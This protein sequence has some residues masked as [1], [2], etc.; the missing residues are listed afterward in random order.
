[1]KLHVSDSSSVHHQEFFTV[2]AGMVSIIQVC[3]QAVSKPVWYTP[4][5]CVQWKTRD[6]GQRNCPKHVVSFQNKIWEISA[7][8]W[9]Y[10]KKGRR[11]SFLKGKV[12]RGVTKTTH[13][14]VVL[15]LQLHGAMPGIPY[16]FVLWQFTLTFSLYIVFPSICT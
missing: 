16:V 2:H 8:S 12:A 15:K 6:G 5:L 7:F 4:F 11:V 9:F 13:L 3:S 10:Y 14:H 1:M